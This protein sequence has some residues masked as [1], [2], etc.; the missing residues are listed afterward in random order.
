MLTY[1]L[2]RGIDAPYDR[3]VVKE[4]VAKTSADDYR[5]QALI[6]GIVDSVPFQHRRGER[7]VTSSAPPSN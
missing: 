1:A 2:G 6:Q 5:I 7:G 4:V 3:L